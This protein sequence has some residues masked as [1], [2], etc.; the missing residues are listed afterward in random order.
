MIRR[1]CLYGGPGSGKSTLSAWLFAKL[2]QKSLNIEFVEEYIKF[3]ALTD[4]VP[5]TFD[6]VY[7]F[8]KQIYKEFNILR[9]GVR[10]II[11]E[12]PLLLNTYYAKKL[13]MPG[14]ENLRNIAMDFEE[15]YPAIHIC[16]GRLN[17]TYQNLGRYYTVEESYIIDKEIEEMLTAEIKD[18][19]S[20]NV[21]NQD[22]ILEHICEKID[23]KVYNNN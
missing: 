1:I 10:A 9:R 12:A 22:L 15:N 21:Q 20:F 2:K 23:E 4:K 13:G 19:V 3:W 7:I 14:W 18:F 11:A 17:S 16:L 8:G 5:V 6:Q